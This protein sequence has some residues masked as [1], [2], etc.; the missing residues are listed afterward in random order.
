M[1]QNDEARAL[2]E[3]ISEAADGPMNFEVAIEL[4]G[5]MTYALVEMDRQNVFHAALT[6]YNIWISSVSGI[7]FDGSGN[8]ESEISRHVEMHFARTLPYLSP[9]AVQGMNG[10]LDI[11]S[12]I[13]S[14][15]AVAYHM[16]SGHRVFEARTIREYINAVVMGLRQPASVYNPNLSAACDD[17][18]NRCLEVHPDDRYQLPFE[19]LIAVEDLRQGALLRTT[20]VLRSLDGKT[21]VVPRSG[22]ILGRYDVERKLP[23]AVDLSGEQYGRMVSRQQAKL[24]C[25]GGRWVIVPCLRTT[26]AT[27]LNGCP[28]EPGMQYGLTDGDEL[29]IG[30]LKLV[31]Q[32][33]SMTTGGANQP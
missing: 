25:I 27:V 28:L 8:S 11:R 17:F 29:Q 2:A 30:G 31:L 10:A 22:G 32:L 24:G 6:P 5:Q 13:Y 18:L 14:I 1:I 9:E 20:A 33:Q 26:N 3:L 15:G 12:D 4:L 21:Y 19:M 7:R 23:L 16:L